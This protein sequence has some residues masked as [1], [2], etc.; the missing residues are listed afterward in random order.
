MN[1]HRFHPFWSRVAALACVLVLHPYPSTAADWPTLGRDW[2]R[3]AVSP[4]RGAPVDWELQTGRNV[5]WQA[6][7]GSHSFA[8]PVVSQGLVWIGT[9]NQNPRDPAQ[10]AE[11]GVLM[12]FRERDGAFLYQHVSPARR[13]PTYAQTWS[14]ISGSPHIEGERLWF[15]TTGAEVVCLD[16][17]PL[18]RGDGTPRELW[19]LDL[20]DALGALPRSAVMGGGGICSVAVHEDLIFVTTANGTSPVDSYVPAPSAPAL[21]CLN[22]NTGTVVWQDASPG[23]RIL[24]GEWGSPLVAEVLGRAQVIVPQGDGWIRSFDARSG[25][26]IWKYD[27]NRNETGEGLWNGRGFF[28]TAPVF[29]GGRV[30]IAI[31]TCLEVGE[32]PGRLVC[33]DPTRTGDISRELE[34]EPRR[35]QPNPNSGL[36]WEFNG[37]KRTM[38]QVVIHEGLVIAPDFGG[39]VHCLDA[40]SGRVYWSHEVQAPILSTALVVDGRVYVGAEDGRLTVL[41]LARER[42]VVAEHDLKGSIMSSPVFANGVLYLVGGETLLAVSGKSNGEWPQWRGPD[43]SNASRESGLLTAWPAG[44][45]PLRWTATGLGK[46]IASVSVQKG[47]VYTVGYRDDREF[48]FAL[49]SRT[50]ATRWVAD[51]GPAIKE[52]TLMRWVSQRTP[53]VDGERLYTVTAT[54]DLSCLRLS[55]GAV[56]WRKNYPTEFGSPKPRWGFNDRPLVDGGRLICTPAGTNASMVALDPRTGDVIWRA[57]PVADEHEG[58]AATVIS[59]AGGIRHYVAFLSRSLV[60]IAAEDGRRLWKHL[61]PFTWIASSYTPMVQ[62][63]AVFSA[64]GYNGGMALVRLSREGSGLVPREEYFR[65]FQFNPFQDATALVGEHVYAFQNPGHPVCIELRSGTVAWGPVTNALQGR[66]AL[67]SADGHLYLRG[68]NGLVLLVEANPDRYVEKGSLVIPDFEESSGVTAPVVAE[69]RLYLRDNN[70]LLC[71][72]VASDAFSRPAREPETVAVTLSPAPPIPSAPS[73]P[74]TG[75]DRPPDAIF[76]PTPEDVVASMLEL[77]GVRKEDRVVDLGSGDGRMVILAA[78]TYGCRAVGYEIDAQ[79]V[80]QSRESVRTEGLGTLVT[81]EHEDIFT[82]DLRDAD[83]VTVFLPSPLLERL[84]PQLRRLKP[85]ARIVSHQFEIPGLPPTASR[86][87]TSRDDG[88]SHRIFLWTTPLPGSSPGSDREGRGSR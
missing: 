23:E 34:V 51:V 77:A 4:E 73:P 35:G 59:E 66:A 72:D 42:R 50:G 27:I 11:A 13:G 88:D 6:R 33:L 24:Y 32:Q 64:N 68:A 37:M 49:D 74:R 1:P 44:G 38:S 15:V 26:L 8:A 39:G 29:H 82:L 53:T 43:R 7:I 85:G 61:R 47:A 36:V 12:C 9:N 52:D 17:G 19:R 28:S 62:G 57:E 14:G 65:P 30:Y 80:A 45:P 84:L 81:I 58:Y 86:R 63:D 76:V 75:K 40:D 70:R 18:H 3:N 41:E 48:V 56:L 46:G 5:R 78:R 20:M 31:G 2:T 87:V 83:V 55:N 79:L 10:R 25:K 54:G 69:G 71:Y 21:V 60:G 67:T 16:I 22:K